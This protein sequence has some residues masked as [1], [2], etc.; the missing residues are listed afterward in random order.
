MA[1]TKTS[2]SNPLSHNPRGLSEYEQATSEFIAVT[3]HRIHTPVS[4]IKWQGETLRD[5]TMGPINDEQRQALDAILEAADSLNEL[6]RSLLYAFELEKDLPMLQPKELLLT[7]LIERVLKNLAE[8]REEKQ[9]DVQYDPAQ[10]R[11]RVLADP[12]ISFLILRILVENAYCYSPAKS[13]VQIYCSQEPEGA[14]IS[15][16]DRGCGIPADLQHLVFTKFFRAPNAKRL[17]TDGTGLNLYLAASLAQ[18]TGGSLS[19]TSTEGKGSTFRWFIP[20]PKTARMP[21]E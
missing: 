10:S 9:V 17:W 8:L 1:E 19:F 6:S 20:K 2:D 18:R 11:I 7:Q 12:G 21:W 5:G 16:E 14:V 13:I 4:T 3:A 15:V